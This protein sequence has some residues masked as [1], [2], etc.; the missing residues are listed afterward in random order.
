MAIQDMLQEV[1]SRWKLQK[2][3][4]QMEEIAQEP[5]IKIGFIGKFSS[6]KTSLIN[7]LLGTHF[8]VDI[9]PTTKTICIIEP[10]KDITNNKYYEEKQGLKRV[11]IDF[12]RFIDLC[13]GDKPGIVV[14]QVPPSPILPERCIFVDTPGIDSLK[15]EDKD[16]TYSYLSLLDAAV[17][18]VNIS[19]GTLNKDVQDF[20]LDEKLIPIHDRLV[21]A[22][23]HS[24]L[25]K[26]ETQK[27]IKQTILKQL[28]EWKEMGKLH[29]TQLENKIILVNSQDSDSSKKMYTEMQQ[30]FIGKR[31][32]IYAHRRHES[33]CRLAKDVL[34]TLKELKNK[35]Y[36]NQD[37]ENQKRKISEEIEA[38]ERLSAQKQ[39]EILQLGTEIETAAEPIAQGYA[40]L[41]AN[42][43]AE[44]V[45]T[46]AAQMREEMYQL[47]QSKVQ[48]F[49]TDFT[50][51]GH[52][53]QDLSSG[54]QQKIQFNKDMWDAA[55]MAA[56]AAVAACT[57]GAESVIGNAAEAGG[58]AIVA[59]EGSEK[60]A[61]D[62][63]T[64]QASEGKGLFR[65]ICEAIGTAANEVNPVTHVERLAG[66]KLREMMIFKF[67]SSQ[68]MRIIDVIQ[69]LI[70]EPYQEKV[71]KPILRQ[72]EDKR[73]CLEALIKEEADNFE[74]YIQNKEKLIADIALLE[75]EV[76]NG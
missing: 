60:K 8:P 6:G 64:K 1:I 16:I 17:L 51:P 43:S 28:Q 19:E 72:L 14:A 24:D 48:K 27:D 55:K 46:C 68:N 47:C 53:V 26:D 40:S 32:E 9:N 5:G 20:L 34:A 42:A 56:A 67:I 21:L 30:H 38:M 18:C 73:N 36:D 15:S 33:Y 54:I 75:K 50:L 22:L 65:Q 74:Q 10:C 13:G 61:V 57:G 76:A 3:A 66:P 71:I 63:L 52:V 35:V 12:D 11:E 23:T 70:G 29:A 62:L 4:E 59:K 45:A 69:Q 37:I 31:E 25:I 39:E 7:S 41:L 58:G 2:S 49:L 44:Q